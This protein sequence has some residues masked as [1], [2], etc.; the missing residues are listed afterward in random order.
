[1]SAYGVD[2]QLFSPARGGAVR[3]D[4]RPVAPGALQGC[5]W[6]AHR[7]FWAL[8]AGVLPPGEQIQLTAFLRAGVPLVGTSKW[9]ISDRRKHDPQ[10]P[11]A[12]AFS[13]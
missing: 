3:G 2:T 7:P 13:A 4:K 8:L 5:P 1:M 12:G 6:F 11:A 10:S 9:G